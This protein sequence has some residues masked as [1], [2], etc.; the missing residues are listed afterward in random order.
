MHFSAI[1]VEPYHSHMIRLVFL[2]CDQ[3]KDLFCKG[4]DYAARKRQK[5]IRSLGRIMGFQGKT[6]LHDTKA[7]HDHTHSPDQSENEVGE[8]VDYGNG[9]VGGKCRRGKTG[10]TKHGTCIR[11]QG[12]FCLSAHRQLHGF[13]L[14]GILLAKKFHR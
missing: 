10:H 9:I 13:F 6:D 4:N 12:S 8:V 2:A 5:S 7:K 11:H 14:L 1:Y 3:G